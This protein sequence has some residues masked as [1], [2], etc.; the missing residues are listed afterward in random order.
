V[1]QIPRAQKKILKI[2]KLWK[3]CPWHWGALRNI[4]ECNRRLFCFGR[5]AQWA[6]TIGDPP[7]T[8]RRPALEACIIICCR[9]HIQFSYVPNWIKHQKESKIDSLFRQLPFKTRVTQHSFVWVPRMRNCDAIHDY[10]RTWSHVSIVNTLFIVFSSHVRRPVNT[11]H[12]LIYSFARLVLSSCID[13][14]EG[15][16]IDGYS[17][18]SGN[19][20]CLIFSFQRTGNFNCAKSK[21]TKKKHHF[22]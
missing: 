12:E 11:K 19:F 10:K 14:N 9:P 8:P 4:L 3:V 7:E 1:L 16:L 5:A 22:F 21:P 18:G 13:A 15:R 20:F 2:W 6:T 17:R